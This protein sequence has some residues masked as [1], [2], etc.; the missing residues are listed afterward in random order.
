[1]I[2]GA[3][4]NRAQPFL[5]EF[6]PVEGA[7]VRFMFRPI[8]GL[9]AAAAF[10]FS[11]VHAANDDETSDALSQ[12]LAS[13]TDIAPGAI[14]VVSAPSFEF[15]R[16]AGYSHPSDRVEMRSDH[17]LRIGSIT[18]TYVAALT[19]LASR[20]ELV[21]L[22]AGID[23]YLGNEVLDLLPQGPVPTVRQLLNHTSGIPD[24]YGVRFYLFDW[25]D[26]GPL[27]TELVLNALRGKRRTGVPG[28]AFEYSN[29]NYHLLALILERIYETSL[30]HLFFE[31]IFAPLG[32][33]ETYYGIVSPPGDDI[34]GF[35]SPLWPW[36]ATYSWQENSG[37]D[38]GMFATAGDLEVWLRSLF[39]T[40]G[41]F[42]S[43]GAEMQASAVQDGDRRQQGLGVE[44]LTSRTGIRVVGHTGGL[45]GYLTAAYY[46]PANDAF[47]L[48]HMNRSDADG[49]GE[50]LSQ[51]LQV[52]IAIDAGEPA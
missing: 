12:I 50:V 1:V 39:A 14:L 6:M 25:R 24:Y 10:S 29:T 9:L 36:H 23:Q 40:D 51:V 32:L 37:P 27:T 46:L 4:K 22:D 31:H 38:G 41:A 3:R 44:M 28:E 7:L 5:G 15:R 18:K 8:L 20:E 30:E 49:F 47:V 11:N 35:G 45:D 43:V 42:A 17:T 21:D 16:S 26:R 19:V 13:A 34:H 52:A 33:S 48:L 2:K